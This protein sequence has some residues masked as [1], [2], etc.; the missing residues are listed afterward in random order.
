[1]KKHIL[2]LISI[3]WLILAGC[4]SGDDLVGADIQ[5]PRVAAI[6]TMC[7]TLTRSTWVNYLQVWSGMSN[8]QKYAV[9]QEKQDETIELPAWNAAQR[10]KIQAMRSNFSPAYYDAPMTEDEELATTEDLL[11]VFEP[12]QIERIFGHVYPYGHDIVH[13]PV[14]GNTDPDCTC[15]WSIYCGV[16]SLCEQFGCNRTHRGCGFWGGSSCR[17]LCDTPNGQ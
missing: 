11:Q 14:I 16:L 12:E 1:M 2:S 13:G 15:L 17:G 10:T 7:A 4:Q 9:W 6:S 3:A 5:H 8:D